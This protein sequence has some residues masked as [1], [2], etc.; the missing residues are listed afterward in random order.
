MSLTS[1]HTSISIAWLCASLFLH[2]A[3]LHSTQHRY[4]VLVCILKYL[5]HFRVLNSTCRLRYVL[6]LTSLFL[7]PSLPPTLVQCVCVCVCVC[8]CARARAHACVSLLHVYRCYG[9]H[10]ATRCPG[11]L[12]LQLC[13]RSPSLSH[14]SIT[15]PLCTALCGS[16]TSSLAWC[17]AA[18][19][20]VWFLLHSKRAQWRRYCSCDLIVGQRVLIIR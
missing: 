5:A 4:I 15:R 7:S 17:V 20:L 18:L 6:H 16:A 19:L 10:Q 13:G 2:W 9:S 1:S 14:S 11:G 12:G 8:V 3:A